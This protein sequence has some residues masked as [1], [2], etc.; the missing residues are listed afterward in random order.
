MFRLF[1]AKRAGKVWA[2]VS[3]CLIVLMLVVTILAS[4]VFFDLIGSFLG[5]SVQTW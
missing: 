2:I 3:L 5:R 4:T 1:L